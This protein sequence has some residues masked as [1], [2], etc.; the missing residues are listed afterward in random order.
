LVDFGM[1]SRGAMPEQAEIVDAYLLEAITALT[2]AAYA[3]GDLVS[4]NGHTYE[5]VKAGT[6]VTVGGGLTSTDGTVETIDGVEFIF[7]YG[8]ACLRSKINILLGMTAIFGTTLG[9][10]SVVGTNRQRLLSTRRVIV[11]HLATNR[12]TVYRCHSLVWP[13]VLISGQ[14]R[15]AF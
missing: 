5:V 6:V 2:A 7:I 12:G 8:E 10:V 13:K 1:L 15:S 4:S 14:R 9:P 3:V 11:L